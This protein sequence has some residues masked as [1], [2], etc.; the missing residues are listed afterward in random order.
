MRLQKGDLSELD[1]E[2]GWQ[3][4]SRRD[5]PQIRT[6]QGTANEQTRAVWRP[7]R[8]NTPD[9]GADRCDVTGAQRLSLRAD[10]GVQVRTQQN[11]KG[12]ERS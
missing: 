6:S 10:P 2:R 11:D 12:G 9:N 8:C 4:A 5:G 1:I 7:L 3:T